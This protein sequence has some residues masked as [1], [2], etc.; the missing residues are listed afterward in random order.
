MIGRGEVVMPR[1]ERIC[2]EKHLKDQAPMAAF[3]APG[4]PLLDATI[5]LL[6][7]QHGEILK[8]GAL[9]VDNSDDGD[10]I[11]ALFYLEQAV[12]DGRHDRHG[13]Q[14]SATANLV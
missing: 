9:L 5:D 13:N 6:L 10:Q 14:Q 1:Y 12:Q 2:F 4:H 7:E 8:H 11:R 3:V